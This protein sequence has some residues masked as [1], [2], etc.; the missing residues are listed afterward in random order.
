MKF[1]RM[2]LDQ[3]EGALLAHSQR[4]D[5]R[6]LAKGHRL[7]AA[8]VSALTA[9]GVDS[10]MAARLAP[11]D[12]AED[13]AAARIARAVAGAGAKV[14]AAFTGRCNLYANADGVALIDTAAVNHINFLDEAI[15]IATVPAFER[16]RAGQMLATVKIIPFA[17][18]EKTVAA[19]EAI[20]KQATGPT[21]AL[22]AFTR[23]AAGL[24]LTRRSDTKEKVLAKTEAT[25]AER[26][27]RLGSLL[28]ATRKVDHHEAAIA[29]AVRDLDAQG[30]DPILIFGDSA[31]TDRGDVVPAG[32]IAAGGAVDHMGMPVDPGNLLM[33]GH[34]GTKPVLGVPGCARSPK[35]NGFDWVLE[36]LA[37]GLDISR[38]DIQ[39]MGAGGLLKEI[40]TRPQPRTDK[41]REAGTGDEDT[42]LPRVP[43]IAAILL[44]A[45]QSRRMGPVNKLL[46]E[47]DGIAMVARVAD[48]L[49][50][51]QAR[52]IIVVT[53]HQPAAV[54]EALAGRDLT[55][56]HNP[57]YE[58]GLASSLRAG[59]DAV[60]ADCDGAIITLG[61]MPR[62]QAAHLDRLIAAFNPVEGRAVCVPTKDG[63]RGN[64]VLWGQQF[65]AE[66]RDVTG[67][68]GARH[69]IGTFDELVCDVAID[70]DAIFVDV[71]TPSALSRIGG[72]AKP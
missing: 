21:V 48:A 18:P 70:D 37:A 27:E 28:H 5:G 66:I 60:P 65:F 68:T 32:L 13:Q 62:V 31:I 45:G 8:D 61:D 30:C 24:V 58:T 19:S 49:T 44:A 38:R 51:S 41:A 12:V 10:V 69:L 35:L 22:A 11:D 9:A 14:N 26:L 39:G 6:R 42:G 56:I 50:A 55:F 47:I 7:S 54:Q 72:E 17:A 16:V 64:P 3:A 53:G 59:I 43:R 29:A 33:L 4:I 57:D 63:K 71:D 40:P 15:T 34:L 2:A 46:A 36:R 20:A 25:V 1:G 52:P 23:R 67:D